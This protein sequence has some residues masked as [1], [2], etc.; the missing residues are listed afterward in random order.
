MFMFVHL[1]GQ[2]FRLAEA[3]RGF[4]FRSF[5]VFVLLFFLWILIV[6]SLVPPAANEPSDNNSGSKVFTLVSTVTYENRNSR[7]ESWVLT[8]DDKV[9]GL[10]MN[11]S[12]QTVYLLNASYPLERFGADEDGNFVAYVDF[13]M[14]EL[15]PRE[16]VTYQVCYSIVHKPR[17]LSQIFVNVSGSI[18]DIP[19]SLKASYCSPGFWQSN[20]SLISDLAFT[21]AGNTTNVLS[22]LS[23]YIVWITQNID[24]GSVDTP[25]FPNETLLGRTGDCD[26]Q[27]NLLIGL[28]RAAGIPA[29]LQI[30]CIYIPERSST[31]NYW[32]GLWTSSLKGIGW[33]GWAMVYVPPWGWLPIDLTY[34]RGNS[35]DPLSHITSSAIITDPT[36]QYANITVSNYV[37][38]SRQ[39]KE[40]VVSGMHRIITSDVLVEEV[41]GE[42]ST[43]AAEIILPQLNIY[44]ALVCSACAVLVF[45][46]FCGCV[47]ARD[48]ANA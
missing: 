6:W 23:N 37:M 32:D 1:L 34:S 10:F 42:E 27:A 33:H 11:N 9:V 19:G 30:G 43:S 16:N 17:A 39:F 44:L 36:V 35:S 46:A 3:R 25:R 38:E 41:Q 7:G 47:W 22:I 21:V 12:W 15:E 26:D 24:Y 31:S 48:G 14:S 5:R 13:P 29:Y 45:S 28:C 4:V 2:W 20:V 18:S 8:D 40:I